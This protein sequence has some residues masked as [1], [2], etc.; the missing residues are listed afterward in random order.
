VARKS[1]DFMS[2]LA[3]RGAGRGRRSGFWTQFTGS[4]RALLP[5]PELRIGR[6]SSR[7]GLVVGAA[8][9]GCLL[10]GYLL[11]NAFPLVP[12]GG[13]G[14]LKAEGPGTGPR[15]EGP[16]TEGVAPG[17]IG[18]QEDL[19]PLAGTCL[20]T[21]YY[22][23]LAGA[24][25]AARQLH[26]HGLPKARPCEVKTKD[27]QSRWGL[28]VYYEGPRERDEAVASLGSVPAPD[29]LFD[30]FRKT[31]QDWPREWQVQ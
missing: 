8:A 18:E 23:D 14:G 9:F 15:T 1:S 22:S 12:G 29:P 11:G 4:L 17:I 30:R 31:Q 19:R 3:H 25:A 5:R 24:A 26:Q 27:G 7:S 10:V 16:R 21:A 13:R 6:G 28:V 2:L 20:L